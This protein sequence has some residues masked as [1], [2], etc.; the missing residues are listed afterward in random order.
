MYTQLLVIIVPEFRREN[1]CL[2]KNLDCKYDPSRSCPGIA[3]DFRRIL[4]EDEENGVF[5]SDDMSR[6][7]NIK[8]QTLMSKI[9]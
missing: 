7:R 6:R 9:C 3:L 1:P 2:D 5:C 4:I 8:Q